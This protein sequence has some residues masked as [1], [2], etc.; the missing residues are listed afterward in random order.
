M[1]HQSPQKDSEA[2][3]QNYDG[4]HSPIESIP[5]ELFPSETGDGSSEAPDASGNYQEI[6][7]T[8]IVPTKLDDGTNSIQQDVQSSRPSSSG[9]DTPLAAGDEEF[10][11]THTVERSEDTVVDVRIKTF[12]RP[13]SS[14]D[15]NAGFSFQPTPRKTATDPKP[16]SPT[17]AA[18][19]QP[20]QERP[21]TAPQRMAHKRPTVAAQLNT[22]GMQSH[23]AAARMPIHAYKSKIL[24]NLRATLFR[25]DQSARKHL[26]SNSCS[27][28]NQQPPHLYTKTVGRASTQ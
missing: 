27:Y 12:E 26:L 21:T 9:E 16:S 3:R 5:I 8:S 22:Q 15:I 4:L 2:D 14:G 19:R 23:L 10:L 17:P 24:L 6:M 20:S 18:C 7:T 11:K 25:S 13:K 1:A 28:P